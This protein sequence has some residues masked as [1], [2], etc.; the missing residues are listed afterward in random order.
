MGLKIFGS[1]DR[2]VE[3][4]PIGAPGSGGGYAPQPPEPDARKFEILQA[5]E[6][7]GWT[8]AIVHYPGCTTYDGKK[9][10]VFPCSSQKV[11]AQKLLDPHFL[12]SNDVL[13]PVARFEPTK[14]GIEL[15]TLL[16]IAKDETGS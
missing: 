13:S 8:I 16:C 7:N 3:S 9:L 2:T 6:I 4:R 10:L 14:R 1:A 5:Q 11:R 12:E 15:A